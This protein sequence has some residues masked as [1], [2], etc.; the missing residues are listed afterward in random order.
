[1]CTCGRKRR[2]RSSSRDTVFADRSIQR[3]GASSEAVAAPSNRLAGAANFTLRSVGSDPGSDPSSDPNYWDADTVKLISFEA[4]L[5]PH[6][7][8]AWTRA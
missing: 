2:R 4:G 5:P 1:M 6:A 7:F 8:F 3:F